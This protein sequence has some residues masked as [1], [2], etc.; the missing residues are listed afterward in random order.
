M[1]WFHVMARLYCHSGEERPTGSTISCHVDLFADGQ[2]QKAGQSAGTE[3]GAVTEREW[4]VGQ[5]RRRAKSR[6]QSVSQPGM[7]AD[8]QEQRKNEALRLVCKQCWSG[9]ETGNTKSG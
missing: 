7:E 8:G 3:T 4:W 9:S 6:E 1:C 5:P 2:G